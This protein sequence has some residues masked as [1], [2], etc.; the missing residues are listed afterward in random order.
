MP[1]PET[2]A[3]I[4]SSSAASARREEDATFE[5]GSS[6]TDTNA[7]ACSRLVAL[8]RPRAVR[9]TSGRGFAAARVF[10]ALATILFVFASDTKFCKASAPSKKSLS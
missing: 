8:R 1:R 6:R 2:R 3:R 9:V 10:V 5:D 7:R 4:A